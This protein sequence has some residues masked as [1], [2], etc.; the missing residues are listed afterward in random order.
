MIICY[1]DNTSS[2]IARPRAPAPRVRAGELRGGVIFTMLGLGTFYFSVT[3]GTYQSCHC[4]F[5]C[6]WLCFSPC[7]FFW[8]LAPPRKIHNEKNK[9]NGNGNGNGNFDRYIFARFSQNVPTNVLKSHVSVSELRALFGL[10]VERNTT[11][12]R[13]TAHSTLS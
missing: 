8:G 10:P 13:S 11:S 4:H 6:H 12:K 2:K 5:H 3:H 9:A 1:Y 7:L